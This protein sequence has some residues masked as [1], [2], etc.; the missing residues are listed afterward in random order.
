M[1]QYATTKKDRRL[2]PNNVGRLES[3]GVSYH[4]RKEKHDIQIKCPSCEGILS[5]HEEESWHHC[6]G[7]LRCP[8]GRM[9][10]S[11]LLELLAASRPKDPPGSS[12]RVFKGR[13]V[14]HI[15]ITSHVH[16]SI[17]RKQLPFD[18]ERRRGL[19]TPRLV[20]DRIFEKI[21][22]AARV[23]TM[24]FATMFDLRNLGIRRPI[25]CH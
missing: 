10:F 1:N 19:E 23:A 6:G 22:L 7:E 4:W 11:A 15:G 20:L 17:Q 12:G 2:W 9:S 5:L 3:L 18:D 13:C 25:A 14:G 24:L 21:G 8:M 16:P